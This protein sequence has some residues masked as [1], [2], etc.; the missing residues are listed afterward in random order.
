V[1]PRANWKGYLKVGELS[2]AV[3]L[4]TAAS[5][6]ERIAFH[7]INRATGHRVRREFVDSDSGKP[8][9]REN[10]V[11]GYEVGDGDHVVL[12][13]EEIEAVIPDSD[14]TLTVEAFI[15]CSEV[16]TV[17]FDRPYYLAPADKVA[18]EAFA[19][20]R[21]GMRTK[22][23]AMLARSL[24]FRRLRTLMIRPH[25]TGMIAS[26]LN[27]DYEVRDADDVFRAVPELKIE[28]EMLDLAEHIIATKQG[29]F[30]P[31]AFDD[32]YE[33]ALAELVRAKVEGKPLPKRKPAK[34]EP[35]VDLL[36]ALRQS[37]AA[38]GPLHRPDTRATRAADKPRSTSASRRRAG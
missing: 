7:T 38:T 6:A 18:A 15:S 16:D 34:P 28:G 9:A 1:A 37:A 3:G 32:R 5:T 36:E 20:I 26:T 19:L 24:L 25:E 21:E 35:V 17:Y 10:Q 2:C 13:P 8:V 4:Y 29:E 30:D 31:R 23:V 22:K 33:Q 12:E 27:F 14:K 11:K